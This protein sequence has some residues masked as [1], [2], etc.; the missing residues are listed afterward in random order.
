MS[1]CSFLT[2]AYRVAGRDSIGEDVENEQAG[3][4]ES[5]C[6]ASGVTKALPKPGSGRAVQTRPVH[7]FPR[8]EGGG[9]GREVKGRL[10][11][12]AFSAAVREPESAAA[13]DEPLLSLSLARSIRKRAAIYIRDVGSRAL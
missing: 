6:R 12:A 10:N 2:S 7:K 13:R 3:T 5:A 11:G 9:R 8:G 4:R 1:V